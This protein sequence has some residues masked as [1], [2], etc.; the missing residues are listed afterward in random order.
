MKTALGVLS[1]SIAMLTEKP[2]VQ[3]VFYLLTFYLI[4]RE[5]KSN[6]QMPE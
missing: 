4:Y 2:L 6:E 3:V 1:A 5:F